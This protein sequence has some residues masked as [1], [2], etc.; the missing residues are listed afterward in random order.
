LLVARYAAGCIDA[1]QAEVASIDS[2]G[3][4]FDVVVG[5]GGPRTL[6]RWP[7]PEV[8]TSTDD[9][10]THLYAAIAQARTTAGDRMPT[11]SLEQESADQGS[12]PTF[13]TSVAAVAP[14]AEGLLQLELEG[15]L[16]DYTSLGGDQFFYLMLPRPGAGPI[17]DGYTMADYMAQ[18]VESRPIGA[19]YTVRRWDQERGRM[20]LWAVVHGHDGGVSGW[21]AR[22]AV[23]DRVVI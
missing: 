8:L 11:T 22:C 20:T 15:G 6:V 17:P 2:R 21:A 12:I 7:F 3:V 14:L 4:E 13:S 10:Y 19:Y 18:D 9:A 16:D 1:D 23:G 5:D